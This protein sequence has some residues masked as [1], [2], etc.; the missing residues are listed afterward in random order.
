MNEYCFVSFLLWSINAA[1][2]WGRGKLA[3]CE[4]TWFQV[5]LPGG[6]S[7]RCLRIALN[8][9]RERGQIPKFISVWLCINIRPAWG[10]WIALCCMQLRCWAWCFCILPGG[11][12]SVLDPQ[13]RQRYDLHPPFDPTRG[14][15]PDVQAW[16]LGCH[17]TERIISSPTHTR[18]LYNN[19][20]YKPVSLEQLYLDHTGSGKE[21]SSHIQTVSTL[22]A[23]AMYVLTEVRSNY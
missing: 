6:S 21:K 19:Y 9:K 1:L 22:T 7:G 20:P 12:G 18:L 15:W 3:V 4:T 11:T 16:E 13:W 5:L 2:E 10:R 8:I 23:W 14:L 17:V